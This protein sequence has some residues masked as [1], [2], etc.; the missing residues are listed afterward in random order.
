[1]EVLR[2]SRLPA[3]DTNVRPDGAVSATLTAAASDAPLLVT[4]IVNTAF[5]PG[6]TEAGPVLTTWTSALAATDVDDVDE[7][8]PGVGSDVVDETVAVLSTGFGV[9]YDAGTE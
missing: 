5:T 2:L 4:T 6:T 8:L 1:M 7:L 3:L 9:V